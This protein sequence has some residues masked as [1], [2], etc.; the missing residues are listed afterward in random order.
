MESDRPRATVSIIVALI[1]AIATIITTLVAFGLPFLEPFLTPS[2]PSSTPTPLPQSIEIRISDLENQIASLQQELDA[3][4]QTGTNL[5][6]DTAKLKA[7]ITSLDE[8]MLVIEQ[9]VLDNP[10][11][12]LELT[13]FKKDIENI[14][15]DIQ[16]AREE[17]TRTFGL[18]Q[19]LLGTIAFGLFG[20]AVSNFLPKRTKKEPKAENEQEDLE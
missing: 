19:F 2:I 13:L 8:R 5:N 18:F 9:A 16:V 20:L 11:K 17:I 15:H 10:E 4:P 7:E 1:G 12:A 6:P 3:L 14:N